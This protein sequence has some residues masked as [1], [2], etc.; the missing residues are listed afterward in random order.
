[1]SVADAAGCWDSSCV[2]PGVL[3]ARKPW[4]LSWGLGSSRS[5]LLQYGHPTWKASSS[6]I[7]CRRYRIGLYNTLSSGTSPKVGQL[8]G[9]SLEI[10]QRVHCLCG[11]PVCV[12][13]NLLKS[14]V[15]CPALLRKLNF[16]WHNRIPGLLRAAVP[17]DLLQ[18][19]LSDSRSTVS[20]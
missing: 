20:E 15:G 6:S 3:P 17:C 5:S 14:K 10:R 9:T 2:R 13:Y 18:G 7:K 1:M 19:Q 11:T 16:R 8:H 4:G 12:V